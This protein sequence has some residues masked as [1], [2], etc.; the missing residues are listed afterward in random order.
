V[1][2]PAVAQQS[3]TAAL[4]VAEC[5]R[6]FTTDSVA[7]F[8][9][10]YYSLRPPG[11]AA[12]RR[13]A[14]IDANGSFV[15]PVRDYSLSNGLL[16]M[17]GSYRDG[18]KEGIFE[19]YY[20]DG[21]LAVRG[22]FLAGQPTGDWQYWYPTGQQRQVL[23]YDGSGVAAPA[24]QQYWSENGQQLTT[25]GNGRWLRNDGELQAEGAVLNGKPEGAWELRNVAQ[26]QPRLMMVET[27]SQG[28]FKGGKLPVK[29]MSGSSTYR[30]QS[31][32]VIAELSAFNRAEAFNMGSRCESP[33]LAST[34]VSVP[35]AA[36][37]RV[38]QRPATYV[39]GLQAYYTMFF[40]R[41]AQTSSAVLQ[42]FQGE[43][44]FTIQL[45]EYGVW[46]HVTWR[47]ASDVRVAD[48]LANVIRRLPRWMP[49]T[50][51][52]KAVKSL[53]KVQYVPLGNSYSIMMQGQLPNN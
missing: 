52:G 40:Q 53:V 36:N 12:L 21:K 5:A 37:S 24:I 45:D 42:E 28:E 20:P 26:G 29:P 25:N 38:D 9:D 13:H 49:A 44:E 11:C 17:S 6:V 27:F 33:V 3:E 43:A 30:D 39:R 50:Q 35:S 2:L 31:R 10:S 48:E 32:I 46:Q 4:T 22:Q 19:Q 47:R 23:R 14:R 16:L 15:G 8:Y 7:L 18:K 1:S 34:T 51:N 41:M